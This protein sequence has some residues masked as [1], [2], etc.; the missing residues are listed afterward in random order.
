MPSCIV[1]IRS[2]GCRGYSLPLFRVRGVVVPWSVAP[3]WFGIALANKEALWTNPGSGLINLVSNMSCSDVFITHRAHEHDSIALP[4]FPR[5]R[6]EGATTTSSVHTPQSWVAGDINSLT[7]NG[8]ARSQTRQLRHC[9]CNIFA[10][11]G[12]IDP[13]G[14][15]F[16]AEE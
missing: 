6:C 13:K 3:A 11:H 1:Y 9:G 5:D 15:G 7:S 8:W 4:R 14:V 16:L 2:I 10:R 12:S